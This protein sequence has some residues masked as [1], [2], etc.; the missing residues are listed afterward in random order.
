MKPPNTGLQSSGENKPMP[1][2]DVECTRCGAVSEILVGVVAGARAPRCPH[3]GSRKLKR[4]I[5]SFGIGGGGG[6][7]KCSNCSGGSCATCN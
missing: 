4:K 1:I 5:S 3:C 7:G 2:L 6:K